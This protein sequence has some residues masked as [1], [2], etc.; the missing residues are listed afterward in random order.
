MARPEDH[1]GPAARPAGLRLLA[2]VGATAFVAGLLAGGALLW[3][4]GG[5]LESSPSQGDA[6]REIRQNGFRLINPLLECDVA[7]DSVD[8]AELKRFEGRIQRLVGK[9]I[10]T[11][12]SRSISVYF[13]D[14]NNGPWFGINERERFAPA[15]LL[16]L[17]VL[18]AYLKLAE[19]DPSVLARSYTM[20]EAAFQGAEHL[21]PHP[22]DLVVG[23][24]YTVSELLRQMIVSSDNRAAR[25]LVRDPREHFLRPFIDLQITVPGQ[26]QPADFM[27]VKSYSS[28]FRILFNASY[29]SAEKSESALQLLTQ[30]EFR[31][32]LVGGVPAGVPVAHKYGEWTLPAGQALPAGQTPAQSLLQFHDCGIVYYPRRPYLLCVMTRGRDLADLLGSI[33]DISQEV[34]LAVD[35]QV[36]R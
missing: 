21:V 30:S 29:L 24:S 27:T 8:R 33:R 28:F 23:Q 9:L 25:L 22:R 20:T 19:S 26:D 11:G 3:R 5:L 2:T 15:S 1:P 16:K 34:Y 18:M 17:P 35:A 6:P 13:R 31:H 12:K 7:M 32:G 36:A 10:E 4:F 14:L